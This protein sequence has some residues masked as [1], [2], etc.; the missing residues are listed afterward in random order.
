[1]STAI[2][3]QIQALLGQL[4]DLNLKQ[5]DPTLNQQLLALSQAA[6]S[7][8]QRMGSHEISAR[9]TLPEPSIADTSSNP[10]YSAPQVPFYPI[11]PIGNLTSLSSP[12]IVQSSPELNSSHR[13]DS[14]SPDFPWIRADVGTGKA[15]EQAFLVP[16]RPRQYGMPLQGVIALQPPLEEF[17]W[18]PETISSLGKPEL[19]E[20]VPA[21][22]VPDPVFGQY[23]KASTYVLNSEPDHSYRRGYRYAAPFH[24]VDRD[25]ERER[26]LN[27]QV[28]PNTRPSRYNMRTQKFVS[29]PIPG[30]VKLP[31]GIP[32]VHH[33]NGDSNRAVTFVCGHTLESLKQFDE[34]SKVEEL[35]PRL[36]QLTWGTSQTDS[37]PATPG[38][39][40][41]PGMQ[42]NLRS[43]GIRPDAVPGDG[44]YNLAS[45]HGEGEGPGIFMPAVQT[46]I[47][48]AGEHIKELLQILHKLY[49]YI[50]PLSLSRVEWDMIEFSAREN[51][52]V[53]FG[54][55]EPGPT[56]CQANGSSTA[57]I[58][59]LT[60]LAADK[61]DK[62]YSPLA[63]ENQEQPGSQSHTPDR[64]EQPVHP[65]VEYGP[66]PLD[67]LEISQYARA[68][69]EHLQHGHEH[70][71]PCGDRS[72]TRTPRR[73][74]ETIYS[75]GNTTRG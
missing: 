45:T 32:L 8:Q 44:S 16:D 64:P 3:D 29:D 38:I 23:P 62:T 63:S 60:A 69:A 68:W 75:S 41:L 18:S 42:H 37:A 46:T 52:V 6:A 28:P 20:L 2:T 27:I 61:Q 39:F 1:M 10:H 47:P 24:T 71:Q 17:K 58:L 9:S 72:W 50:M 53:A 14:L 30:M 31:M 43:K 11:N 67:H 7:A 55:L 56:S 34:G 73:C 48:P 57:N 25:I 40:E 13:N 51:N 33:V 70:H 21:P 59:D 12:P 65:Y 19:N 26:M 15:P 49:R 5:P 35:M 54:G 74:V 66:M 22:S 4:Q 36:L